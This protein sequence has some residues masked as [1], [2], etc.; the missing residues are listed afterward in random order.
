MTVPKPDVLTR[1]L[2][3]GDAEQIEEL[4]RLDQEAKE[5]E[6]EDK[7]PTFEVTINFSG[8]IT[9][10]IKAPDAETA[11]MNVEDEGFDLSE[12]D[13]YDTESIEVNKRQ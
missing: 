3:F 1:P 10:E 9:R 13:E 11:K 4:R 6:E 8:S 12:C 5:K 7:W 2:V